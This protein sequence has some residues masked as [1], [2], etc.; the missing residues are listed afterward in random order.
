MSPL[1]YKHQLTSF[2]N[3]KTLPARIRCTRWFRQLWSAARIRDSSQ[4]GAH[5]AT[6]LDQLIAAKIG[7]N[8]AAFSGSCLETTV[9][10]AAWWWSRRVLLQFYN[11]VPG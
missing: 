2:A 8:L 7:G 9:Q 10:V 4:P 3:L 11:F 5:M 6:T 1:K